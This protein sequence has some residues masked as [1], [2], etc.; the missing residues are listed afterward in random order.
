MRPGSRIVPEHGA[1]PVA[2][3]GA[4]MRPRVP[5]GAPAV[6]VTGMTNVG[7]PPGLSPAMLPLTTKPPLTV[8]WTHPGWP[9][10]QGP[11]ST[12]A[13]ALPFRN[14]AWKVAPTL[15]PGVLV[16]VGVGDR[17]AVAVRI[18]VPVGVDGAIGVAEDVGL[19]AGPLARTVPP[20]CGWMPG[21]G[22]VAS[23]DASPLL[24]AG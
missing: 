6:V 17:P 5:A 7:M 8:N 9:D 4:Q 24:V 21:S 12:G 14:V 11:A 18:G 10:R 16:A 20:T 15:L 1:A 13:E 23:H 2:S 3:A 22:T 19:G